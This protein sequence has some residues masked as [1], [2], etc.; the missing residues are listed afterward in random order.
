MEDKIVDLQNIKIDG[1][2]CFACGS[3]IKKEAEICPKCGV[4]QNKR[5][6]T[7][8]EEVYCKACGQIMKNEAEIC[9]KCGVRQFSLITKKRNGFAVTS[10]V[11]GILSC[12]Y[13]LVSLGNMA[14]EGDPA[15]TNLPVITI[16]SILSVVFGGISFVKYKHRLALTGMI[17]CGVSFIFLFIG[18]FSV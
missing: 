10:L 4:P 9:I 2:Y 17:L 3:I 6:L 13:S 11:F 15:L 12:I 5:I 18:I 7:T 8:Q 16:F 14:F 1:A